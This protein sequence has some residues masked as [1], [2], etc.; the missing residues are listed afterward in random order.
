MAN[1][2]IGALRVNLGLD[3]AQFQTGLKNSK[4]ALDRFGAVAVKAFA[5]VSAAGV[6]MAG[7]LAVGIKRTIDEADNLSKSAQ[8][9]GTTTEELARFGHAADLSGVSIETLGKGMQRL[10][11][12]MLDAEM[13][14]KAPQRA[15][16]LLGISIKNADGTMKTSSQ[17]MMEVADRFSRMEDGAN[18]TGIAMTLFG[19]AGA[20]LIPMFNAGAAGLQAMK[21]EADALGIVMDGN[22]ARAAENF[23][24]NLTRL[25]RVKAGLIMKITGQLLPALEN[26]SE[27]MINFA[28]D[29]ES[30]QAVAETIGEVFQWVAKQA[31]TLIG[32]IRGIRAEIN[33]LAEV[34][35]KLSEFDF[36]GARDAWNRG[37]E[38]AV[39]IREDTIAAVEK[40]TSGMATSQA[41]I[42][43]RISD[44]FGE[45]GAGAG[46]AF[47]A[48]F[49]KATSGGGGRAKKAIDPMAREAARIFEATRSPL[50]KYQAEIKRLNELL[51]AGAINQDTYNRAV[52]Q[53]QGAFNKAVDAGKNAKDKLKS[54]GESIGATFANAFQGLIDG[55]RQTKDVLRDLGMQL[56]SM[57][58]NWAFKALFGSIGSTLGGGGVFLGKLFGGFRANGGPVS[59][60]RA[61]VV[62]ERGPELMVPS[63][64]GSVISN[65]DIRDG[66]RS[67]TLHVIG[68]EGPMF[69]PTIQAEAEGVAVNVSDKRVG[70]YNDQQRRGGA[71]V[72]QMYYSG[73]K[74]RQ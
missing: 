12:N 17:I 9:F 28:N 58:I 6:A 1:A 31:A 39:K 40:L 19:R 25:T 48:N 71:A 60:G 61:Y 52:F 34:G 53:A 70:A 13:G 27:Q 36:S 65:R 32:G 59:A 10:S 23:N 22:T 45:S 62:G 3:S 51:A 56:S 4:S 7:A 41:G 37:Q 30:V 47:V 18:K 74:R 44:A 15:F 8:K 73:L 43:R 63:S 35:S 42:Q 64:A 26:L 66:G 67:I 68:E 2:V 55:S 24:D 49:E 29:G 57:A 50:E 69:R 20:E 14:L 72:N 21:D 16:D 38:E 5:A 33:S 11:R 46:E 54:F